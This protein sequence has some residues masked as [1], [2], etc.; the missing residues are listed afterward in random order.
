MEFEARWKIPSHKCVLCQSFKNCG[1]APGHKTYLAQQKKLEKLKTKLEKQKQVDEEKQQAQ[2]L[3]RAK[4]E[5][6]SVPNIAKDE[7]WLDR[8]K[9]RLR[10]LV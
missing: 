2:H 8:E 10:E 5:V 9:D 6:L 7:G 1:Y 3:K 4:K